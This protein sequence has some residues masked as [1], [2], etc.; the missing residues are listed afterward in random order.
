M[1]KNSRTFETDTAMIQNL[2]VQVHP[3]W[4]EARKSLPHQAMHKQGSPSDAD[5]NASPEIIM[6]LIEWFKKDK[7]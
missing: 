2:R 5:P 3:G 4:E 1:K 7:G 6:R